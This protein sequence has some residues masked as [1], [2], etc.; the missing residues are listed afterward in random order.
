M[1]FNTRR[2]TRVMQEMT[3]LMVGRGPTKYNRFRI[4]HESKNKKCVGPILIIDL[5]LKEK[6]FISENSFVSFF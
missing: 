2:W 3:Q 4:H 5:N 6:H 1:Y